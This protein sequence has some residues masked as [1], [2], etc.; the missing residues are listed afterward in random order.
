[1][2]H[3]YPYSTNTLGIHDHTFDLPSHDISYLNLG[4]I[5]KHDSYEIIFMNSILDPKDLI[6]IYSMSSFSTPKDWETL[7]FTP[8][9]YILD[10]VYPTH[11]FDEHMLFHLIKPKISSL[12]VLH[13]YFQFIYYAMFHMTCN[14][15]WYLFHDHFT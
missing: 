1:M 12:F 9:F 15:Q 2:N 5:L 10:F 14:I 13:P 8:K 3:V 7:D 11:L 6:Q 4:I